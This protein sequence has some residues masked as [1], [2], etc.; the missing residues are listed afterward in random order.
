MT[1]IVQEKEKYT[2]QLMDLQGV[3]GVGIGE[4]K[5]KE[6]LVVYISSID[7]SVKQ[8][9]SSLLKDFPYRIEKTS[10]LSAL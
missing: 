10:S 8:Q 4:D 5:G 9:I 1:T 3:E 7:E 6:V 2:A